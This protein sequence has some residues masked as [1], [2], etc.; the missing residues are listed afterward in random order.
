VFSKGRSE[1]LTG[2]RLAIT[3]ANGVEHEQVILFSPDEEAQISQLQTK[4]DAL[5][6]D[7]RVGLAAAS[8][9]IW[10]NLMKESKQ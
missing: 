7:K 4:F 8:R 2:L 6:R 1:K 9:A 10:T 3:Q 5:L